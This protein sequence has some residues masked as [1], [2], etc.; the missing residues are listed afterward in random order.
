MQLSAQEV[1]T[2]EQWQQDLRFLQKTINN[3]FSFLYKKVTAKEFNTAVDNFYNEIPNLEEHE[4]VVGFSKVISLFKYGHTY[5]SF[6][7][8]PYE[9]SQFPFNLYQ[10]NDGIYVEGTQKRYS[11]AVGAKVIAVE[12]TP[13]V[14]VL[15]AIK[16]TVEA[17]N[18]QYFKAYGI[19]NIRYPEVLHAQR[20]TQKLQSKV[21][22]TLEKNG[23]RFD[24]TFDVL[25][26]KAGLPIKYG[27][28]Q[29]DEEWI[30]A[31]NQDETPLYLKNFDKIFYYEY[32]PNQK[33]VYVRHSGI[34]NDKTETMES[35]Y[36]RVFE[37]VEKNEVEKL[38]LDVRLNGGGNNYLLKPVITGIIET[39]K[40]NQTGKLFVI[41]GRRTFSACQNFVNRLHSYTNAIFVGEPTAENVNFYGDAKPVKLPN[42]RMEVRLSF[43]W[44]Q[45]KEPWANEEWLSPQLSAD[46]SFAEYVKNEDPILDATLNF[47]AENFIAR[48]MDHIRNLFVQG[49]MQQLQ[50]DIAHMVQDPKYRFFDFKG[51]F[52]NSGKLL[53]NQ[54]QHR[55][56]IGVLTMV[57]Q[58]YPNSGE[59]WRTLGD[60]YASI[61]EKDKAEA[62]HKK[63]DALQVSK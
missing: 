44:W 29:S 56:A 15:E 54:G 10:F 42:S 9:F 58:L 46:M 11:K 27:F 24:Q 23:E 32:L 39:Q 50:Q 45:D 25:E 62:F 52:I 55:S 36:K 26:N 61:G 7:Q 20:I 22:L 1:V 4:I 43:A 16:P 2:A 28:I 19:N 34:W 33:A 37:F 48:P 31:R 13:I 30:S 59:A 18:S 17:E 14:D 6:H 40:I 12:G 3:D 35:F 38:I 41:T 21:T 51:K 60:G 5:V 63:A 57:T 47:D 49:K 8:K 53:L